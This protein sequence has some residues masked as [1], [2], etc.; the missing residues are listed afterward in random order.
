MGTSTVCIF[1]GI[2][3]INTTAP[4]VVLLPP[5]IKEVMSHPTF[6]IDA[7]IKGAMDR[8]GQCGHALILYPGEAYEGQ[9]IQI[10]PG[11]IGQ[12]RV[13]Y[14]HI[15]RLEDRILPLRPG[16]A[17]DTN[18][19][20]VDG[21]IWEHTPALT[22]HPIIRR[23]DAILSMNI[24]SQLSVPGRYIPIRVI[25]RN[26]NI[27]YLPADSTGNRKDAIKAHITKILANTPD[28]QADLWLVYYSLGCFYNGDAT[29]IAAFELAKAA[30]PNRTE[31]DARLSKLYWVKG[32]HRQSYNCAVKYVK[33]APSSRDHDTSIG[34]W[35]LL[36]DLSI[37]SYHA[38]NKRLGYF[39][40]DRLTTLENVPKYVK[41]ASHSNLRFLYQPL[42]LLRNI[43][44][45]IPVVL[46]PSTQEPFR[47]FNP[48][49]IQWQGGYLVC[50]RL[51]NCA[52]NWQSLSPDNKV[53]NINYLINVSDQLELGS[54]SPL[55]ET[56]LHTYK[57]TIAGVEDL[58]LFT[59]PTNTGQVEPWVVCGYF[60]TGAV[61]CMAKIS[62]DQGSNCHLSSLCVIDSPYAQRNEK[63]WSP[64]PCNNPHTID[65]MYTYDR[66]RIGRITPSQIQH[67][68]EVDHI[69]LHITKTLHPGL[70]LRTWRGSSAF[71]DFDGGYLAVCHEAYHPKNKPSAYTHRFVKLTQ[72]RELDSYSLPF[73][74]KA[75]QI[76]YC[77]GLCCA[78]DGSLLITYGIKDRE[79][80]I[81]QI[82]A[83]TVRQMLLPVCR[84][85]DE[86]LAHAVSAQLL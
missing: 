71:I 27:C 7:A 86:V 49:I 75:I 72:D 21:R 77:C 69:K 52:A 33:S 46:V 47:R 57:G 65:V 40:T 26:L 67:R 64:L 29:S 31:A 9:Q 39:L 23:H 58:R 2:S 48:S 14:P 19:I 18:G 3:Q 28:A 25:L 73:I 60:D 8:Y 30:N 59:R 85:D 13:I 44:I 36:Y 41:D 50:C 20:I 34:T 22:P 82:A 83:D 55:I 12:V 4:G 68:S 61:M 5:W 17:K 81:G 38:D 76:E 1:L 66:L 37:A 54:Y 32:A 35:E 53:R 79:A 10:S 6:D 78:Y 62:L 56:R 11:S 16:E 15:H 51:T 45:T 74:F 24:I 63:N 80:H 42:K 84:T 70:D 43:R